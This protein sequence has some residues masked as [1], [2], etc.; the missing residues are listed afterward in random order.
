MELMKLQKFIGSTL[1]ISR[2]SHF[3]I[4]LKIGVPKKVNDFFKNNNE[5]VLVLALLYPVRL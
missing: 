2:K 4:W 3:K 1:G 5:S